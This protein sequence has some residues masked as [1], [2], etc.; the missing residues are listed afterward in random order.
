MSKMGSSMPN[1]EQTDSL[2]DAPS[3][4]MT[5]R[6]LVVEDLEDARTSLQQMLRMALELP[7][8]VASDGQEAL[9]MLGQRPYSIAITD[10]RMPRMNGMKLIEEI[11]HRNLPVT[12][13]VTTGHGGVNE[14]VQA[15]LWGLTTS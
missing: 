3:S 4:N 5:Q 2:A 15:M 6:L 9:D 8:D 1:H 14:A 13:L 7:V 12:V 10:L 11:Q